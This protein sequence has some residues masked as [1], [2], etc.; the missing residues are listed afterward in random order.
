MQSERQ[1]LTEHRG[2]AIVVATLAAG[3]TLLGCTVSHDYYIPAIMLWIA[4]AILW[5]TR[6]VPCNPNRKDIDT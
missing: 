3:T 5:G 4:S 6:K 1:C 2:T